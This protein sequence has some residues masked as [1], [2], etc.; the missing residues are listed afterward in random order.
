M[1]DRCEVPHCKG[2]PELKFM[3]LAVCE[4]HWQQHC[5]DRPRIDLRELAE[6][7]HRREAAKEGGG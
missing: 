4:L 2:V 7:K 3:G 5:A 6:R 1:G